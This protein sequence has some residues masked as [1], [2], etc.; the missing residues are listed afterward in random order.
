MHKILTKP[1]LFIIYKSF[2]RPHLSGIIY[3]KAYNTSFHQNLEK[4][5]YNSGLAITEAIR[6]TS[7]EKLFQELELDSLVKMRWY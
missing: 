5:Q 2:I 1:P 4:I 6:G 7:K 3:D